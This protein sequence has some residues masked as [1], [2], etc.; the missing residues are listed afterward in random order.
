LFT[1]DSRDLRVVL[2]IDDDRVAFVVAAQPGGC[3]ECRVAGRPV[4]LAPAGLV[5]RERVED[6]LLEHAGVLDATQL[7]PGA[8]RCAA[9]PHDP[10]AGS[11][12]DL[13]VQLAEA[14]RH[15]D[16]LADETGRDV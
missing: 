12:E 13:H 8:A 5:G 9:V 15:R 6:R 4:G 16:G 14:G 10:P 7:L 11:G 1:C 3:Y 2:E